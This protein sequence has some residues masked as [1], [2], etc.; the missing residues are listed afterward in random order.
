MMSLT[1]L[2]ISSSAWAQ[3]PKFE[4]DRYE[5]FPAISADQKTVMTVFDESDYD[6][7][8]TL[9]VRLHSVETGKVFQ[10]FEIWKGPYN[11]RTL[12][13]NVTVQI[14]SISKIL[15]KDKFVSLP[16]RAEFVEVAHTATSP[17]QFNIK[18]DKTKFSVTDEKNEPLKEFKIP[19]T[20]MSGPACCDMENA[21]VVCTFPASIN[22]I[23]SNVEKNILV[24]LYGYNIVRDG[25]ESGGYILV[26][27]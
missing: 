6:D 27:K 9:S 3:G 18:R 23:W 19:E 25:C 11:K 7:T 13:A 22:R 5:G 2:L 14:A 1:V 10:T 4:F 12:D 15:E 17:K 20:K 21:K 16:M 8:R 26:L 24:V